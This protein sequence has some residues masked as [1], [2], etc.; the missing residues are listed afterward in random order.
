MIQYVKLGTHKIMYAIM[1]VLARL[2]FGHRRFFKEK[3][4][5]IWVWIGVATRGPQTVWPMITVIVTNFEG[6]LGSNFAEM[7][8]KR[9]I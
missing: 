2:L 8:I 6:F 9:P 3:S 5:L 1:C 7:W 4:Q